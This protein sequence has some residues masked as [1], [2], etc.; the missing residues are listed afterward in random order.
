VGSNAHIKKSKL[1]WTK[2]YQKESER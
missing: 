2:C 1:K